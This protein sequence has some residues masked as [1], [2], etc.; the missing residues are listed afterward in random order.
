MGLAVFYAYA[1]V[2][3]MNVAEF[4]LIPILALLSVVSR[5]AVDWQTLIGLHWW[6]LAMIG[7]L[8]LVLSIKCRSS[9]RCT[10]SSVCLVAALTIALRDTS[11]VAI[12]GAIPFHIFLATLL[13]IGL[14]YDDRFA[15]AL[16]KVGVVLVVCALC[17]VITPLDA[18]GISELGRLLYAAAAT[19]VVWAYW[20]LVRDKWWFWA[21]L[22]NSPINMSCPPNL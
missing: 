22:A 7:G 3:G 17:T 18:Y 4:G 2:R 12:G 21:A 14:A 8:Q 19:V 20:W 13:L 1:W 6:P 9:I 5:Q 16:R 15:V 11:F 10:A